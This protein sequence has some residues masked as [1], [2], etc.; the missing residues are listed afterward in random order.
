ME[1]TVGCRRTDEADST[2]LAR[3]RLVSKVVKGRLWGGEMDEWVVIDEVARV[4]ALAE[5]LTDA[6]PGQSLFGPLQGFESKG[7]MTCLRKW[8]GHFL[9]R[10]VHSAAPPP[11]A[12][13]RRGCG[14]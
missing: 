6:Q 3:Y 7:A 4:I 8:V 9:Q 11:T 12:F 1:L 14:G 5:Q 2:G 10:S 13:R